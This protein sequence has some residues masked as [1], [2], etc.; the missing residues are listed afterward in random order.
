MILNHSAHS[1]YP[2]SIIE[3][4]EHQLSSVSEF[5]Y[6][7]A[8]LDWNQPNTGDNKINHRIQFANTKF[9]QMSK[10]IVL[11]EAGLYTHARIG[12]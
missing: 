5:K 12:I 7:G 10:V 4:N 11:F 2:S 3:L 6:L 1:P 8:Y 9:Q